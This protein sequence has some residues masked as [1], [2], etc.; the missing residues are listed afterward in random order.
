V[1]DLVFDV[2]ESS[3]TEEEAVEDEEGEEGRSRKHHVAFGQVV[4]TVLL[5][6]FQS[7]LQVLSAPSL[8]RYYIQL[9][10]GL[11]GHEIMI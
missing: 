7:R 5:Y 3:Q 10:Q 2:G 1:F 8:R 11:L 6:R 9:L 4:L